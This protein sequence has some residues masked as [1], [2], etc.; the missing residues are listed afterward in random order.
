MHQWS[1]LTL[2]K[3]EIYQKEKCLL[4]MASSHNIFAA[5]RVLACMDFTIAA[6]HNNH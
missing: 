3:I 2:Q 6:I 5:S 1:L 4:Q